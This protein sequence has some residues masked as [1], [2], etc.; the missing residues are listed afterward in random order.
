MLSVQV[1]GP[2]GHDRNTAPEYFGLMGVVH[3][4]LRRRHSGK[5][6]AV[7]ERPPVDPYSLLRLGTQNDVCHWSTAAGFWLRWGN[8][9]D[10]TPVAPHHAFFPSYKA[11]GFHHTS[12]RRGRVAA[13]GAG[14]AADEANDW[15]DQRWDPRIRR[16]WYDCLSAGSE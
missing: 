4:P 9:H 12:W 3:G 5:G 11:A 13:H 15:I 2:G 8:G 14:G 1:L 7:P 10:R 6:R 16:L